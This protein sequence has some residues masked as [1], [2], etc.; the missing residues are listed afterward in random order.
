MA[1]DRPGAIDAAL[2]FEP[3][4]SGGRRGADLVWCARNAGASRQGKE[5][6][7]RRCGKVIEAKPSSGQIKPSEAVWA[8]I[9]YGG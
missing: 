1:I 4:R 7:D 5:V 9:E 6:G 8:A 3:K 2:D